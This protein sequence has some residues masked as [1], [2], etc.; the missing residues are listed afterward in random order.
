MTPSV[1]LSPNYYTWIQG[2]SDEA[3]PRVAA[4][5]D[6]ASSGVTT[7]LRMTVPSLALVVGVGFL[8]LVSLILDAG[9][10]ALGSYLEAHFSGAS[11]YLD[12]FS[13]ARQPFPWLCFCLL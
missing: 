8:L 11:V 12:T 13:T 1:R 3:V 5:I 4:V 7:F 2:W 9:V 6:D 10:T